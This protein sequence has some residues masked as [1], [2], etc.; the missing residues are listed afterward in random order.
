[1]GEAVTWGIILVLSCAFVSY[2]GWVVDMTWWSGAAA[3]MAFSVAIFV[4]WGPM[5]ERLLEKRRN[6][7]RG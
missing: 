5:R 1:M 4:R 6:R 3:G 2:L 7:E